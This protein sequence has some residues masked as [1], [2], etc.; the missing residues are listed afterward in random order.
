MQVLS[1]ISHIRTKSSRGVC[2]ISANRFK[3]GEDGEG[4]D[5]CDGEMGR[6]RGIPFPSIFVATPLH[7]S[8]SVQRCVT[9]T[10]TPPS[11]PLGSTTRVE[12]ALAHRPTGLVRVDEREEQAEILSVGLDKHIHAVWEIPCSRA[13]SSSGFGSSFKSEY[14]MSGRL[15]SSVNPQ[16]FPIATTSLPSPPSSSAF[17]VR[18]NPKALNAPTLLVQIA[19]ARCIDVGDD[20]V[21]VVVIVIEPVV[22]GMATVL[23]VMYL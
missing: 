15:S 20:V 19:T 22:M 1:P 2:I 14:P 9:V 10:T 13:H 7:W 21:I 6:G 17:L 4:A 5:A 11:R 16:L 18:Y 12:K 8:G 3:K 23:P